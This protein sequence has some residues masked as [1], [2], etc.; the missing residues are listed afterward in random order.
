LLRSRGE[1]EELGGKRGKLRLGYKVN[2]LINNFKNI[3][4]ERDLNH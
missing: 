3:L 1:R 2:I 4:K